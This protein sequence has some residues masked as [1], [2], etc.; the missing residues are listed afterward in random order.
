VVEMIL[1]NKQ[2]EK[3]V[4]DV[5]SKLDIEMFVNFM[6]TGAW[7]SKGCQFALEY[8]YLTVPDMIKDKLL[9]KFLKI[10]KHPIKGIVK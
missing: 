9:N 1:K 6:K 10:E 5:N 7:G 3:R 4:F 8:P 2:K